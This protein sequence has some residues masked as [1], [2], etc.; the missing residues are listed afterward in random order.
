[1]SPSDILCELIRSKEVQYRTGGGSSLGS[2]ESNQE[3]ILDIG[4]MHGIL[5]ETA[6]LMVESNV[7]F[8]YSKMSAETVVS[9][10]L[11]TVDSHQQALV[12]ACGPA[13]L[14]DAVKD[15]TET[16]QSKSGYRLDVH[17]EHF[18]G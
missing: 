6:R 9:E 13:S 5:G 17:L 1:M 4:D 14:M 10:A 15:S 7:R 3:D 16:F 2:N 18:S 12:V 8:Q 11:K